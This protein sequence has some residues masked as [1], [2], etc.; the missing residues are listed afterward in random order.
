MWQLQDIIISVW[1][2]IEKFLKPLLQNL[3]PSLFQNIIL[4]ILAIF[5]P[6]A[7]VFLTDILGSKRQRSEFEKMVLSEEVLDTKK[8]FWLSVIGI[9][10]L[11][12]FSGTD[13]SIARKLLAVIISISLIVLF[14]NPFKRILRFSEGYKLEFQISFL[15]SLDLSCVFRFGNKLKME[16]MVRAWKS[17]WSEKS[18]YNE[19]DF[20][21]EFIN[22]IDHAIEN[23]K[24]ELAVTLAQTYEKNLDMRDRF[25]IGYEILPKLFEWHEKFWEAEQGWLNRENYKEKTQKAFSSKYFPTFKKWVLSLLNKGCAVDNF[26]WNWHYF[27]QKLFPA[28]SRILLQGGHEPYQLFTCFKKY[29]EGAEA[30]LEK[31]K[32]EDRKQQWWNYITGLFGSFCPVFFE[33]IDTVPNNFDIWHHYFPG[34]W[35]IASVNSKGRIPRVILHEFLQWT[36]QR[37]FKEIPENYDKELTEVTNGI[38][39]NAHHSLFPAFLTLL[40][41]SE[42]KYAV[43]KE[44]NFSLTNTNISWFGEKSE[45]EVQKMFSQQDWSQKEETINIIYEY[46]RDWRL[47]KIFRNDISEEE[48]SNWSGYS[49]E[50]RKPIINRVRKMKLQGVLDELNSVEIINLC[51]ESEQCEYRRKSFI[52]L[53]QLLLNRII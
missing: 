46:F 52:E 29:I 36:Q 42:I 5:I 17:F 37:I 41:S 28:V 7:I 19:R 30:K 32:D 14:W 3:D 10:V 15:K 44:P 50:Q 18:T 35:K 20:T 6:F 16:R 4:G 13:I 21:K 12:F 53:I 33:T 11:A 31:I 23:E 1:V 45:E 51:K 39:P 25:S 24:Y 47:L 49:E 8:V 43:Q 2:Y 9:V 26:F 27:L 38:F 48:F 34:E 40:F 22:H